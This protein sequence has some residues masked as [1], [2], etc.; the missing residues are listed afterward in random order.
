MGK[1]KTVEIFR[2]KHLTDKLEED[3]IVFAMTVAD[4]QTIAEQRL[5]RLLNYD[6]MYSV[7]KGVEWGM[8]NWDD[9]IKIA[10]D[11][12]PLKEED[13]ET[14]HLEDNDEKSE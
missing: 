7:R 12:L 8:D 4:V 13:K 11:S 10:I 6:E 1:T 3:E 2:N 5:G 14:S 9:I